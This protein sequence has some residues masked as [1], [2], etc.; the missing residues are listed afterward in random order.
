VRAEQKQLAKSRWPRIDLEAGVGNHSYARL[1]ANWSFFDRSADYN[2]DGAAK[3]IVA[4]E[5]RHDLMTRELTEMSET[6]QADMAKSQLQIKAAEA[7]IGASAEVARLY[8]MQFKVGRRSLIELVNAYAEQAGVEASRV[9]AQSD[10]RN[11]VVSYMR[12]YAALT[13]WAQAGR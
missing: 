8:E 6:A 11:A 1:V 5:R 12:A 3:Q 9:L 2:V 4:A 7:Q 13:G 10:W